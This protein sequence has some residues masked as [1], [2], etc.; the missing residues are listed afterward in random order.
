MSLLYVREAGP[1]DAPTVLFLHGLRLSHRMW[2]P[3]GD[4]RRVPGVKPH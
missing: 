3:R 4:G 2:Q 1:T